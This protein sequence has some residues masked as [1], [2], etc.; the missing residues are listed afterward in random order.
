M[1]FFSALM[2]VAFL[3]VVVC[4]PSYAAMKNQVVQVNFETAKS[5]KGKSQGQLV[6]ELR[7]YGLSKDDAEFYAKIDILA[8]ELERIGRV[9]EPQNKSIQKYNSTYYKAHKKEIREQALNLDEAALK[10]IFSSSSSLSH[11][12]NDVQKSIKNIQHKL[13]PGKPFQYTMSYPDGSSVIFTSISTPEKKRISEVE[14]NATQL[15]GPWSKEGDTFSAVNNNQLGTWTTEATWEFK[16]GVSYSSVKDL[17]KWSIAENT[18]TIKFISDTGASS[19]GGLVQVDH[20][21]LSNHA[22]GY[23]SYGEY[24]LQGY[25]DVRFK[26]TGSFSAGKWGLE[27]SVDGGAYWHQYCINEIINFGNGSAWGRYSSAATYF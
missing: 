20:E 12:S 25:T 22:S 6:A 21:N 5:H 11:G 17:L 4:S 14:T 16:T 18:N 9:I 23:T 15:G 2:S 24:V 3:F 26:T 13:E 19:S 8:A 1:R 27:I 10:T 7:S